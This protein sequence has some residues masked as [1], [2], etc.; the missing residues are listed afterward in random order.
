MFF[1]VCKVNILLANL[2]TIYIIAS[3]YYLV[4]TKTYFSTPLADMIN[5]IPKL[6]TLKQ[7]ST[8]KRSKVFF[9]GIFIASFIILYLKPFKKCYEFY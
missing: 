1:D 7:Q 6:K 2:A 9:F 8:K 4:Y 5:K 3:I